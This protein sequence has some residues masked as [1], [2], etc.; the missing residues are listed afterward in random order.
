[1]MGYQ[2]IDLKF[3]GPFTSQITGDFKTQAVVNHP[4]IGVLTPPDVYRGDPK[5]MSHQFKY[6]FKAMADMGVRRVVV[7]VS[8][9]NDPLKKVIYFYVHGPEDDSVRKKIDTIYFTGI[10]FREILLWLQAWEI[11][12]S[13]IDARMGQ[14]V[15]DFNAR[16]T[17]TTMEVL[18]HTSSIKSTLDD[19]IAQCLEK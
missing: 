14:S 19:A 10:S 11:R 8:G 18:S 7:D 6:A 12:D 5:D 3:S 15:E 1:M 2:T 4:Q 13:K 9:V 16:M 17:D